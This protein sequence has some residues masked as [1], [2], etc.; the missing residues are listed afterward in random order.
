M[1][2]LSFFLLVKTTIKGVRKGNDFNFL[3]IKLT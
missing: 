2:Y 1:V 3:K